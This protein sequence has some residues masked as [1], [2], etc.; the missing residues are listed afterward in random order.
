MTSCKVCRVDLC[1]LV[2]DVGKCGKFCRLPVCSRIL[3][4]HV[5]YISPGNRDLS[6]QDLQG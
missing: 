1:V 4:L 5:I 6:A 3:V 2:G